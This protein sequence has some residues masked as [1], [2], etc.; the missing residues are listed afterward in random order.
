MATTGDAPAPRPIPRLLGRLG[1]AGERI[2]RVLRIGRVGLR[3][4]HRRMPQG[5]FGRSL[6]IIIAPMVLLQ[7]V[8]V[9]VF[10]DRHWQLVTRRLTEAVTRDIAAIVELIENTPEIED[11][12]VL[13]IA[14]EQL[15]LRASLLPPGP[16]PP[17]TNRPFIS[18]LDDTL[19]NELRQRIGRPFWID[20]VGR[21]SYV[22]IR[23][24]L[25]NHVLRIITRRSQTYASNSHIFVVW[26]VGTALVLLAAAILFMRNQIRPIQRLAYAAEQ[27]GKGRPAP[28][29]FRPRGAREVRMASEA[30]LEM[31]AR[32]ER[33]I[34]QR[35][36]MLAGVSHDLRTVL[37]R[38]RLELALMP[39]GPER[40]MLEK[41]VAEMEQVLEEY[42]AFA[43]GDAGEATANTDLAALLEEIAATARREGDTVS[44]SVAG[45]PTVMVRPLAFKRCLGN[46]VGNACRFGDRVEVAARHDGNMLTI[47]IDDDGPG[48]PEAER[49]K[50]FR[51]FYRLNDEPGGG[52]GLG[53]A[54]AR[55]IAR[56]HGG[57]I[58]LTD[59]P[60]GGLRSIL[61]VPA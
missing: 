52:T 3:A 50:V 61:T 4:I 1:A 60:L 14:R 24:A 49:E 20:T 35:T 23:I 55:D 27:F 43:R 53:L 8:L 44:V 54:I 58:H 18:L 15:G 19:S 21:S 33:Q 12:T 36:A 25:E 26:M 59:S 45:D 37:T 51:P 11:E 40:E 39:P 7:S 13:R 9:L 28:P 41:D 31:R 48:I 34:E 38:F 2:S 32:I 29:N 56:G 16:L 42:L 47:T 17:A 5:L 22:E 6:I 57:D 30:F 46:L 10:M